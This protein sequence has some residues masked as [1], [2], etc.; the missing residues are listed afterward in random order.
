MEQING[1]YKAREKNIKSYLQK[2]RQ[3]ISTF[4]SFEIQQVLRAENAQVDALS[5]L[6]ASL[7][8]ELHRITFLEALEKSSLEEPLEVL[9]TIHEP[10]WMDSFI[11][12][13]REGT[14]PKDRKKV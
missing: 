12:F 10:S 13:L 5:K 3:L 14:L 9:Q 1:S 6:A 8:S 7:P 11:Q 4:K 2:V